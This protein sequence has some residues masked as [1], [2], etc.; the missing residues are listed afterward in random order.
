[1]KKEEI[2]QSECAQRDKKKQSL[3]GLKRDIKES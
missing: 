1:M 3:D 2:F